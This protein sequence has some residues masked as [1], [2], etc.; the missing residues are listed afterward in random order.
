MDRD[1]EPMF[2]T[3]A[4]SP[5]GVRFGASHASLY[6]I[7]GLSADGITVGVECRRASVEFSYA[8]VGVPGVGESRARITVRE[9]SAKPIALE[10]DAERLDLALEEETTVGGWAFGAAARARISLPRANLEITIAADRLYR[11][12]D[13]GRLAVTPSVPVSIRIRSGGA[14]V[15][16]IDRWE[17][18]GRRSPRLVLDIPIASVARIRLGRG[19]APVRIGA[20]LALRVKRLEVSAGRLDQSTGGVITGAA[21]EF[22]TPIACG[23][24]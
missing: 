24:S 15:S 12:G 11:S 19:E 4:G 22:V 9:S 21:I 20:A 2:G 16:W 3:T 8:R 5:V 7:D 6:E 10:V 17:G 18:D 23:G 14:S 13:L 1:A